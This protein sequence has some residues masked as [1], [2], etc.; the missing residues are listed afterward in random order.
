MERIQD[1]QGRALDK[2]TNDNEYPKQIRQLQEQ[3]KVA[4]DKVKEYEERARRDER[5]A[6]VVQER[7]VKLEIQNRE[8]K[9]KHCVSN[10]QDDDLKY[11]LLPPNMMNLD[12]KLQ[13]ANRV[14]SMLQKSRDVL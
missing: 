4:R 1:G 9:G 11:G 12:Y 10:D 7:M 2:I 8:L 6:M 3:V 13:E 5:Q 14:I